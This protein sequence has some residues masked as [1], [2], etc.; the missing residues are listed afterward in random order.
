L[1]K[2]WYLRF[3]KDYKLNVSTCEFSAH[4]LPNNSLFLCKPRIDLKLTK[5]GIT[6]YGRKK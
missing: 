3:L 4:A 2:F 1:F 5:N 6:K